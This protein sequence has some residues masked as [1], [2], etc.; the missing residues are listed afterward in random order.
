MISRIV[1]DILNAS[2]APIRLWDGAYKIPW[3]DPSFSSRMLQEHLSQQHDLASRRNETIR[4]QA[5][6]ICRTVL[7]C[8]SARVLDLG[9]GPGLYAPC[10][11]A[12]GHQYCG[13]DFSPA[14][15]EYARQH[16]DCSLCRFVQDDILHACLDGSYNLVMM[17]YGEYNVFP[18]KEC[19]QLLQRAYDLLAPGG[20]FL[21]EVQRPEI[22]ER[23]GKSPHTWQALESGLFSENP[24]ICL[25]QPLWVEDKATSVHF[26]HI[27]EDDTNGS[28][29]M[30]TYRNT[31]RAWGLDEL[32][33]MLAS[34]GFGTIDHETGLAGAVWK[35]CS[36]PG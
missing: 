34:A 29:A 22:V 1:P 17:L 14:A 5:A 36:S 24:H 35:S 20:Q 9:C 30:T 28:K 4:S 25:T 8:R 11:A 13:V 7:P 33:S 32:T 12:E 19:R 21:L 31:T 27:L 10:I 6:W 2:S 3:N 18:P 16:H 23:A 26:F 15:I